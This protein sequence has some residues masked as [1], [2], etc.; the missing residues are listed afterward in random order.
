[1]PIGVVI[2]R[3]QAKLPHVVGTFHPV[4]RLAHFL[5]CRQQNAHEQRHNADDDKQ[6]NE[7]KGTAMRG[8]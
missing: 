6:L 4:R 7:G 2:L 5:N 1:M 3:G 8:W